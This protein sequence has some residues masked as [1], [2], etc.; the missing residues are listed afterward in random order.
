METVEGMTKKWKSLPSACFRPCRIWWRQDFCELFCTDMRPLL[1]PLVA[2]ALLLEP[3]LGARKKRPSIPALFDHTFVAVNASHYL[4]FG[5]KTAA[6][7]NTSFVDSFYAPPPF[8][9]ASS[10]ILNATDTFKWANASLQSSLAGATA[11][12]VSNDTVM[13]LYG[14]MDASRSFDPSDASDSIQLYNHVTGSVWSLDVDRDDDAPSQRHHHL[15]FF[16]SSSSRLFVL[17]GILSSGGARLQSSLGQIWTGDPNLYYLDLKIST[18]STTNTTRLRTRS[19]WT[20]IP[21]PLE[22]ELTQ[23]GLAAASGVMVRNYILYCFGS[24]MYIPTDKCTLFDTDTMEYV[25]PIYADFENLPAA[26]EG[27]R[28][29]YPPLSSPLI[30]IA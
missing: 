15:S 30:L 20:M 24:S 4:V 11:H 8:E 16:N 26:R 6:D 29:V 23:A 1:V 2:L 25:L 18:S 22:P 5:G 7:P 13:I 10:L 9:P 21:P 14:T 3:T 17:G 19:S 27:A 28:M 12:A